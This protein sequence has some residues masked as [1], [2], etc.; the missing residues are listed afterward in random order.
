MASALSR[1]RTSCC[2]PLGRIF[3]HCAELQP[4]YSCQYCE[5]TCQATSQI[6]SAPLG[7][8]G[9]VQKKATLSSPSLC[10]QWH[11]SCKIPSR[12]LC[13]RRGW[14][15]ECWW[16]GGCRLRKPH[17]KLNIAQFGVRL[18]WWRQPQVLSDLGIWPSY[19]RAREAKPRVSRHS[20][21]D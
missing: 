11:L 6:S 8:R 9:T 1:R 15:S 10:S 17:L 14:P 4:I 18:L 20:C 13:C 7:E 21:L 19:Y 16:L 12:A 2:C 5:S 3:A